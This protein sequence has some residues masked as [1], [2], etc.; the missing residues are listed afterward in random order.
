MGVL[1][2]RADIL[3]SPG[4]RAV[5]SGA[6][7]RFGVWADAGVAALAGLHVTSAAVGKWLEDHE[8]RG[9]PLAQEIADRIVSVL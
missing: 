2:Q 3:D 1:G 9:G 7:G 4:M 8:G 6:V 5:M